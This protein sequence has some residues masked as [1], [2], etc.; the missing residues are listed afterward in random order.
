MCEGRFPLN[1]FRSLLLGLLILLSGCATLPSGGAPEV[2]P[3]H[4]FTHPLLQD[5]QRYSS[6]DLL[7]STP[8]L[9]LIIPNARIFTTNPKLMETLGIDPRVARRIQQV[10]LL[11]FAGERAEDGADLLWISGSFPAF[12]T[13]IGLRR[14]GWRRQGRGVW[15]D[16]AGQ[17]ITRVDDDILRVETGTPFLT[18]LSLPT[19]EALTLQEV[20][21]FLRSEGKEEMV[22]YVAQP[23]FPGEMSALATTGLAPSAVFLHIIAGEMRVQARMPTER[24][25]RVALVTLRFLAAGILDHLAIPRRENFSI[26]RQDNWI[27]IQ[28]LA[29]SAEALLQRVGG[30]E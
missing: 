1:G 16:G 5:M 15:A 2:S 17:Q 22:L 25:A 4:T 14:A 24:D 10:V 3:R 20:D 26:Q 11:S 28:G 9:V 12:A 13:A 23:P 27:E 21:G 6:E 19:S 7:S 8:S 30:F 18:P 29:Y